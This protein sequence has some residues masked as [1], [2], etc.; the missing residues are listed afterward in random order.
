MTASLDGT[1]ESIVQTVQIT[2]LRFTPAMVVA[3]VVAVGG[4][5]GAYFS[6]KTDISSKADASAVSS[7]TMQVSKNTI[8]LQKLDDRQIRM[9][10][11]LTPQNWEC[12]GNVLPKER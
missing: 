11:V 2:S 12:P 5:C 6:L 3:I 4:G 9:S 8:V 10:C 1:P 7:L